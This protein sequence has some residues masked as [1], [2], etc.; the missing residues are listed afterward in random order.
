V[1]LL[2]EDNNIGFSLFPIQQCANTPNVQ[3]LESDAFAS[4]LDK[5][6]QIIDNDRQLEEE[7]EKWVTKKTKQRISQLNAFGTK[8]FDRLYKR[9]LFGTLYNTQRLY[10]I[11]NLLY[12]ESHLDVIK[13]ILKLNIKN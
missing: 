2:F 8:Y 9:G 3:L 13:R 10:L 4:T 7:Y 12:C 5:L 11:K 1:R 6:N